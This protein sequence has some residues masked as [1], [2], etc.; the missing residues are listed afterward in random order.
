[1][2]Y[3]KALC[4]LLS[5]IMG[6]QVALASPTVNSG[7][8]EF[9]DYKE[10]KLKVLKA[11]LKAEST[12]QLILKRFAKNNGTVFIYEAGAVA[13]IVVGAATYILLYRSLSARGG[14]ET[15]TNSFF[16]KMVNVG[17]GHITFAIFTIPVSLLA[18][19]LTKVLVEKMLGAEETTYYKLLNKMSPEQVQAEFERN[20]RSLENLQMEVDE[21]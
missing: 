14:G 9:K 4:V 3:V 10:A 1:M 20:Q 15:I 19:E 2:N 8:S 12:K 16:E 18:A 11:S 13:P 17:F 6:F 21:L 7:S 5:L